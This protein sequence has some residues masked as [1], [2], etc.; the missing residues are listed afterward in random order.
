[1]SK[2][3]KPVIGK[4]AQTSKGKGS[5]TIAWC[6]NGMVDGKFTEGLMAIGVQ[7]PVN[8]IP[9]GHTLR[10]QGNQIGRQRQ[11]LIDHWYDNIGDEWILWI[12]S[13]IVVDI[14]MIAQLWD[15]AD[16]VHRPIVS[17]I[18]F[19]SKEREGS[20]ASPVPCIFNRVTDN[21]IQHI[22]PLPENQLIKIDSAGMGLVIMHKS[23]ITKLREL[24]PNQS[25][26][27]EQEGLGENFVG[28]DIVFFNK[29][30]HAGIPVYAHTGIIAAHMK[31]FALDYDY[32][33]LYWG[34]VEMKKKLQQQTK[35]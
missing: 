8:G 14:N 32:Y 33:S 10:V 2:Y 18:Y 7:A 6:D 3:N 17:G 34:M 19:I 21:S 12:D 24:F 26:F 16:A 13:D 25:L 29:V 31:R 15:L 9:I 5:L 20:L 1:M 22:H 11:A 28:E 23:V 4:P 30:H 35:E 27:A